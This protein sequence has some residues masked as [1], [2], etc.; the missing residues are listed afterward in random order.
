MHNDNAT[1]DYALGHEQPCRQAN[2]GVR[3]SI[4]SPCDIPVYPLFNSVLDRQLQ[5]SIPGIRSAVKKRSVRADRPPP[6]VGGGGGGAA[7]AAAAGAGAGAGAA[8]GILPN[9]CPRFSSTY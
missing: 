3:T 6:D 7:A 8:A 9:Q 4:V 5:T 1:E 2:G